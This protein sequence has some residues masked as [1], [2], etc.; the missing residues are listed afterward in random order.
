MCVSFACVASTDKEREAVYYLDCFCCFCQAC[1]KEQVYQRLKPLIKQKEEHKQLSIAFTCFNCHQQINLNLMDVTKDKFKQALGQLNANPATMLKSTVRNLQFQ[2]NQMLAKNKF[3]SQ[4]NT[5]LEKLL[6]EVV[7]K[8]RI[9]LRQLPKEILDQDKFNFISD[10]RTSLQAAA[11]EPR[12]SLPPK[13]DPFA[14]KSKS[15][16]IMDEQP[17]FG[18][19]NPSSCLSANGNRRT[20][21]PSKSFQSVVQSGATNQQVGTYYGFEVRHMKQ[22]QSGKLQ[23]SAKESDTR[24]NRIAPSM[25]NRPKF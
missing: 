8:N 5:F 6:K 7:R 12:Q 14:K 3:L 22:G 11:N 21:P 13:T 15:E 9:D 4:K 1:F 16:R 25:F 19:M 18:Q 10:L 23:S 20:R 17:P 2:E 24:L